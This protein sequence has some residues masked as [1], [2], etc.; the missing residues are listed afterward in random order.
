MNYL[1]VFIISSLM[2]QYNCTQTF[3]VLKN[4]FLVNDDTAN[5]EHCC[6]SVG[7]NDISD[8]V[9]SWYDYDYL[10]KNNIYFQK[11]IPDGTPHSTNIKIN[12]GMADTICCVKPCVGIDNLQNFVIV[13][14][15]DRNLKNYNDVFLQRYS[16]NCIPQGI[17]LRVNDDTLNDTCQ[18]LDPYIGMNRLTGNFVIAWTDQRN[19]TIKHDIYAQRYN[20]DGTKIGNNFKVNDDTVNTRFY[21]CIAINNRGDF[22]IVWNDYR[23]NN[24]YPDIYAQKYDSSGTPEGTNFKVNSVNTG[25]PV[26]CRP[27]AAMDYSGNFVIAWKDGRNGRWDIYAQ[28]YNSNAIPQDT[29]FQVNDGADPGMSGHI[30]PSAAI[31]SDSGNFVIVWENYTGSLAPDIYMKEFAKNG[32]QEDTNLQ[33]NE[34]PNESWQTYPF[35]AANSNKVVFV[36]KDAKIG[37]PD[38]YAKLTDWN[39]T[40]IEENTI[41]KANEKLTAYPSI[42]NN[43]VTIR[44]AEKILIYDV[45]G[46]IIIETDKSVWDG[47]DASGKIIKPGIYFLKAKNNYTVTKIIKIR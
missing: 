7:I 26:G 6:P 40:G 42:F 46:K 30:R 27:A 39:F 21:P 9:I 16:P 28:R 45:A 5:I 47:K 37:T 43:T 22:I 33:V 44:G 25:D 19:H 29:N 2:G 8:F 14:I 35:V 17:N 1:I 31:N 10:G 41:N 4:D 34:D 15:D 38:I 18:Q 24:N 11:Y 13:W 32:I 23:N 3:Q 12:E 20:Y 36:W